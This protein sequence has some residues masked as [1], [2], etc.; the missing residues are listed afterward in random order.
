MAQQK[1]EDCIVPEGRRKPA[2][3]RGVERPGGGK[4]VPVKEADRQLLLAFATAE[5]PR[6]RRGAEGVVGKDLSLQA[7]R[8]APKAKV[9]PKQAG[10]ARME[11]IWATNLAPVQLV[12]CWD[13]ARS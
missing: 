1:S 13:T 12:L 7:A 10:S 8:K 2:P 6:Q 3:T 11:A 9:K 5:S 4:A